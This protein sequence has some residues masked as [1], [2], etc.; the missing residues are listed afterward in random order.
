[1][2]ESTHSISIRQIIIF[3]IVFMLLASA[4]LL[5]A[6]YRVS[7][8][9]ASLNEILDDYNQWQ[10]DANDLQIGSDYLTEQVRFFVVTGNRRYLDAYFEE[11]NMTRR[12]DK[13]V[14][15]V[16]QLMGAHEAYDSLVSAMEESVELMD[17]EY[18]AMRLAVSGFGYDLATFPEEIQAVELSAVDAAAAPEVQRENARMMVFD[19][20]YQ[21][22]KQSIT[23][24][25]QECL[26]VMDAALET[27][28]DAAQSGMREMLYAQRIMIGVSILAM[29]AAMAMFMRLVVRPL[30][31]A[32]TYIRKDQEIPVEGSDEFRFL[33]REYNS[34]HKTSVAQKQEL[35]Y[36]ATHDNLTGV[37][38]RNGYESIL[39]SVDWNSCALVLFD[40]DQFKPVNDAYGHTMGDKVLARTAKTI[41]NVFRAR[42]Y[43]CRIGG[44]EFAVIMVSVDA[45]SK[46]IIREKVRQINEELRH[47][48]DGT[49]EIHVSS[50]AVY[51][52]LASD[53]D[54][55]F[56]EADAALYRVKHHGG[57]DCEIVDQ[58]AV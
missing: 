14:E 20:F 51:G 42:D 57:A 34:A 32:V 30:L 15:G 7:A 54:V 38:N 5:V 31:T 35:A 13:A 8:V 3:L 21:G 24:K 10:T 11:A 58:A 44:D 40:L 1:M 6:T 18:Y 46:D 17:R 23:G 36:E 19:D 25:I 50:G 33:V 39:K 27:R 2:E 48:E 12:R 47:P 9:Y 52:A 43:V 45:C 16:R 37:Y 22:K 53:Y 41:Q 29:I 49:P 55:L 4:L 26:A 56:R 28:E